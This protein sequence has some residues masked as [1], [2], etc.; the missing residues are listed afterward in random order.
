MIPVPASAQLIWS[1]LREILLF[2]M[3]AIL[4]TRN[5]RDQQELLRLKYPAA[6]SSYVYA[7]LAAIVG[8]VFMAGLLTMW[9]SWLASV[10]FNL[11]RAGGTV[12]PGSLFSAI[13]VSGVSPAVCEEL[14]FRGFILFALEPLGGAAAIT[15]S[16]LMFALMHGSIIALPVHLILGVTLGLLAYGT[17][18]LPLA[19][20]Y[21]FTY[22]TLLVLLDRAAA[23]AS[24]EF[25]SYLLTPAQASSILWQSLIMLVLWALL[26][27]GALK[28]P[29][30]N[31]EINVKIETEPEIKIKIEPAPAPAPAPRV[32]QPIIF[33]IGLILLFIMFIFIYSTEVYYLRLPSIT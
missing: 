29:R 32:R 19:M 18:S 26:L 14:L 6:A 10:G 15:L 9:S 20:A 11:D 16:G 17:N 8:A 2:G 27:G 33:W 3:P 21:H 12:L 30:G 1:L 28:H 4:A 13:L 25:T 31:P 5:Q 24:Q 7:T 22:N 23:N